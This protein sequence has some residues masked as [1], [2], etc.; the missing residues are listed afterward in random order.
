M[1]RLVVIVLAGALLAS[2]PWHAAEARATSCISNSTD[3][4]GGGPDVVLGLPSYDLPGKPDAG[5]VVVFSNV[6]VPGSDVPRSP[7]ARRLLTMDDLPGLAAQA[8]ARFG[9]AVLV[10]PDYWTG[11]DGDYC[12]DLVVGVPG[13]TVGGMQGAGR[14]VQLSGSTSGAL[15][16]T[17]T[18]DEASLTGVGGAQAGA[19]FGSS[20][21]GVTEAGLYVGAPGRDVGGLVDAGSVVTTAGAGTRIQQKG[22]GDG[23]VEAG[24]RFGEVLKLVLTCTA[25][26]LVVGVPH[27]DVGSLKDAGAVTL[28]GPAGTQSLVHQSTP[29]A[30]DWAEAGDAY[31][32][33]VDAF[34]TGTG[35]TRRALVAIGVP[36]EDIGS[37]VNAG[38]VSF[39]SFPATSQTA[40]A[41]LTGLPATLDQGSPGVAGSVAAGDQYG[42]A[43]V[44]GAFGYNGVH[45]LVAT[46]PREDLG[47]LSDVGLAD[48]VTLR[49]D[50]TLDQSVPG[51]TRTQDSAGVADQ[52]EKSDRFAT[53]AS[54]TGLLSASDGNLV[55]V[56]VPGEDVSSVVDA[57]VAH[58]GGPLG[59]GSV[60]LTPPVLQA[61][62]GLGMTAA[63]ATTPLVYCGA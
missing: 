39:A 31:G 27:E 9:A 61:G 3:V 41:S 14:V 47:T 54:R 44:T 18:W 23:A 13:Q 46:S 59:D 10:R 33:S 57:G 38:M 60:L 42:A 19:A 51:T 24:D 6:G 32:A 15:S 5:A 29:G 12:A 8:G 49:D 35:S 52:A 30:G 7:T 50:G 2:A 28:V 22:T 25:Q 17:G 4:D 21:A 45:D 53:T 43:V 16:V 11:D 56:T 62:A 34:L 36:D 20:L 40:Y 48:K 37:V 1:N 58:L 26:L 55:V 63:R